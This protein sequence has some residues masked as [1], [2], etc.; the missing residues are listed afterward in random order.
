MVFIY[1]AERA[2]G[3][4]THYS[5]ATKRAAL[6][7]FGILLALCTVALSATPSL[8]KNRP[9]LKLWEKYNL[10]QTSYACK[11][12]E[13]ISKFNEYLFQGDSDAAYKFIM[14]RLLAN[15]CGD[16][17]EGE[18]VIV[19]ERDIQNYLVKIRAVGEPQEYWV[20]EDAF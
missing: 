15:D 7:P 9:S 2:M 16:F 20:T 10:A 1:A 11:N 3:E 6:A 14:Q 17:L 18:T 8:S 12:K 19:I 5:K 13:S 4:N